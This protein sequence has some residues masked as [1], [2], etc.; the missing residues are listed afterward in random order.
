MAT[1]V[2]PDGLPPAPRPA[3]RHGLW[4]AS[5]ALVLVGAGLSWWWQH[6]RGLS[7]GQS[8]PRDGQ[9]AHVRAVI[10][11]L[12]ATVSDY[13][14]AEGT[15]RAFLAQRPDDPEV[16]IVASEVSNWYYLRGFDRRESRVW[17]MGTL[18]RRALQL[19]P[20]QPEAIAA[21]GEYQLA[22]E[23]DLPGAA[24]LLRRAIAL[25]PE[26]PRWYSSLAEALRISDP[27]AGLAVLQDAAGRFPRDPLIRYNLARHYR[28]VGRLEDLER[29]LDAVIAMQPIANALLWKARIQ[30]WA[31]GDSAGMKASLDRVP[32][33]MRISER[34]AV[35]LFIYACV[36]GQP[37][38]ALTVLRALPSG[39]IDD[40]DFVGPK[41]LLVGELLAIQGRKE[42]ARLEYQNAYAEVARRRPLDGADPNLRVGELWSLIGLD[43]RDEARAALMIHLTKLQRPYRLGFFTNWWFSEIPSAVALGDR[44]AALQLLREAALNPEGRGQLRIALRIDPRMASLHD[45][46]EVAALLGGHTPARRA[47][48]LEKGPDQLSP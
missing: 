31:H 18:A 26:V 13:A 38:E 23:V 2:S 27:A 41:S 34:A 30:L 19:A 37:D 48:P 42:E 29:E 7:A 44:A 5:A 17:D 32:G 40:Y 33:P 24:A 6:H 16:A 47:D 28:D 15:V 1:S 9:L 8:W 4:L 10:F 21:M 3:S 39:W 36:T 35:N 46:P 25:K 22:R 43:R 45:D 12:D 20:D 11:G 14:N